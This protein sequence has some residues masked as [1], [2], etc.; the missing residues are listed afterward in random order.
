MKSFDC[1]QYVIWGLIAALVAWTIFVAT[2]IYAALFVPD[3]PAQ[4][5]QLFT[6]RNGVQAGGFIA[7]WWLA[8]GG[9][10]ACVFGYFKEFNG[11]KC[12]LGVVPAALYV[13]N[14]W[15]AMVF[16]KFIGN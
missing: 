1:G 11:L 2:L 13:A 3:V 5:N 6:Q 10:A 7:G 12:L 4:A 15:S 8:I 9:L 16:V 14:P